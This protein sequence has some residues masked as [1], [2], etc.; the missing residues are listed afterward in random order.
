VAVGCSFDDLD[1]GVR[2]SLTPEQ[3]AA[4]TADLAGE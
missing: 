4:L 1:V 2:H 3:R